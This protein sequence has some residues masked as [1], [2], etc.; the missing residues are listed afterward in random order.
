MKQKIKYY[1]KLIFIRQKGQSAKIINT[2]EAYF[3]TISLFVHNK[4][5][6]F[7]AQKAVFWFLKRRFL[8]QKRYKRNEQNRNK[9]H[10]ILNIK[11]L[12]KAA[13]LSHYFG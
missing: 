8:R 9:R 12:Y 7:A 10:N 13:I 2:T 3:T 1:N 4:R 5:R 6:L 11:Q